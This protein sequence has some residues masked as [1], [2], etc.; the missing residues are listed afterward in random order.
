MPP[1]HRI[2]VTSNTTIFRTT[3]CFCL[4]CIF[5]NIP[6]ILFIVFLYFHIGALVKLEGLSDIKEHKEIKETFGEEDKQ[7]IDFIELNPDNTEC[8]LMFKTENGAVDA[9]G[10]LKTEEG[11]LKMGE[12]EVKFTLLEG[13]DGE[14]EWLRLVQVSN[15]V[16]GKMNS[17]SRRG[18]GRGRGRGML[19]RRSGRG[20]FD[21]NSRRGNLGKRRGRDRQNDEDDNPV[22]NSDKSQSDLPEA[23]HTRLAGS[24]E[25]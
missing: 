2:S 3:V 24:D 12:K 7:F 14:K 6:S 20:K 11:M 4:A 13:E 5:T 25:D 15:D 17:Q 10:R 23:K 18:R 19:G 1:C 16:F 9:V 8:T 22:K 21:R